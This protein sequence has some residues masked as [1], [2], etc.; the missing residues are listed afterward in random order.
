MAFFEMLKHDMFEEIRIKVCDFLINDC[1]ICP[2]F[3]SS[4]CQEPCNDKEAEE[5]EAKA[6]M[7]AF[8]AGGGRYQ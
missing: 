6:T 4:R 3:I 8:N 7:D 2:T 5:A 1:D